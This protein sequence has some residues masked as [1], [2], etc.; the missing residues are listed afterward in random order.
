MIGGAMEGKTA[1]P[2][3]VQACQSSN[4]NATQ[5]HASSRQTGGIIRNRFPAASKKRRSETVCPGNLM[6]F[7]Q[8]RDH[9]R[10]NGVQTV[11]RLIKHHAVR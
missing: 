11:F 1:L 2:A 10:F 5:F 9:H 7:C 8:R 3:W 6:Q 4:V